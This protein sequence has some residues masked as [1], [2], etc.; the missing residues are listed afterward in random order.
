MQTREDHTPV[1]LHSRYGDESATFAEATGATL[2]PAQADQVAVEV[3]HPTVVGTGQLCGAAALFSTHWHLAMTAN[4]QKYADLTVFPAYD[5]HRLLFEP[6]H[7]E[8]TGIGDVLLLGEIVPGAA[9]VGSHGD[10]AFVG[11]DALFTDMDRRSPTR[12]GLGSAE[13][14]AGDRRGIAFAE[15]NILEQ[16]GDRIAFCPVEVN[17][18]DLA[19]GI[20]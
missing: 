8:I 1:N 13:N 10:L 16:I 7:E 6:A 15:N 18:R 12:V 4:V 20:A 19:G 3:V 14:L 17:M 5:N 9:S 2:R 11:S